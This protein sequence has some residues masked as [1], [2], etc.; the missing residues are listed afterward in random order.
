M[1]AIQ[2]VVDMFEVKLALK[3]IAIAYENHASC[4]VQAD[5]KRLQ[6]V[7]MNILSSAIKFADK[8]G[9][10]TVTTQFENFE[11]LNS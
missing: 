6:Q 1:S 9:K 10:L 11:D 2:E 7:F 3:K 8:G 5:K 4:L